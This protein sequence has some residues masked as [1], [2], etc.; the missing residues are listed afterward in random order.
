LLLVFAGVAAYDL[1][2]RG[3]LSRETLELLSEQPLKVEDEAP[4][5]PE[6]LGLAASVQKREQTLKERTEGLRELEERIGMQRRELAAERI[7]I[8]K[9]LQE[10][11][12][13]A[14]ADAAAESAESAKLIKM[15]ESMAPEDAAAVLENLPNPTVAEILFQMRERRAAQIMESLSPDKAAEVT[16]LITAEKI[17]KTG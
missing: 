6:P 9:Q 16:K 11:K 7:A 12:S 15:Y 17:E 14:E 8:D 4:S 2:Q 5:L 1:N 3:L 10:L 13:I